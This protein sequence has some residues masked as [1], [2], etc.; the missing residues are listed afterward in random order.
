MKRFPLLL[1][2]L[3]GGFLIMG[4]NGCSSDPNV[5]GAKL[6]LRNKDYDRALENIDK[7]LQNDPQNAEAY[8]LKGQVLQEMLGEHGLGVRVHGC[9]LLRSTETP[10][11]RRADPTNGFKGDGTVRGGL[12]RTQTASFRGRSFGC[13]HASLISG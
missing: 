9:G 13:R 1:V 11:I 2:L 3:L 10:L 12:S 7:A 8:Y 4:A 5:E 6:D